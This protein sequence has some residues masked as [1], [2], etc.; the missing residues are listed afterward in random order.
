MTISSPPTLFVIPDLA[1]ISNTSVESSHKNV[2][3]SL[4]KQKIRG[5]LMKHCPRL[6]TEDVMRNEA[7]IECLSCSVDNI[8]SYKKQKE[9]YQ[10]RA[11]RQKPTTELSKKM[12]SVDEKLNDLF[13][14]MEKASQ[15]KVSLDL[16]T[17]NLSIAAAQKNVSLTSIATFAAEIS[18]FIRMENLIYKVNKRISQQKKVENRKISNIVSND[19]AVQCYNTI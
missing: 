4:D 9:I 5:F 14:R 16:G 1:E 13:A 10:D 3:Q 12:K 17:H 2:V 15:I 18:S 7:F 6:I 8:T 19:L 11:K